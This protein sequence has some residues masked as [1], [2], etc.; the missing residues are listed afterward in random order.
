MRRRRGQW[1]PSPTYGTTHPGNQLA[2]EQALF[3]QSIY[4]AAPARVRKKTHQDDGEAL[5]NWFYNCARDPRPFDERYKVPEGYEMP[6]F[7][8][9]YSP[10]SVFMSL[11]G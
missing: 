5:Y 6:P 1:K 2:Q 9:E 11:F 10:H 8:W 4:D 3:A 7:P